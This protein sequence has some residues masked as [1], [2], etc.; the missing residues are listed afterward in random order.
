M[1]IKQNIKSIF[2]IFIFFLTNVNSPLLSKINNQEVINSESVDIYSESKYL[3]GPGD[4]L[5]ITF[6]DNEEI[7]QQMFLN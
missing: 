2:F 6:F 4:I 5:N 1:K 7:V 3:I